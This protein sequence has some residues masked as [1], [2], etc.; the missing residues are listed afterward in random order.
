MDVEPLHAMPH[1]RRTLRRPP[2]GL[3]YSPPDP[4]LEAMLEDAAQL[5]ALVWLGIGFVGTAL[6]MAAAAYA[7]LA[8]WI[9]REFGR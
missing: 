6:A 2:V 1:P 3:P 5:P 4:R 7:V 8:W 9:D